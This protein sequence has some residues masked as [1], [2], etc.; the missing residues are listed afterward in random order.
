MQTY[1]HRDTGPQISTYIHTHA[2]ICM[3]TYTNTII[4]T[5]IHTRTHTPHMQANTWILLTC[6]NTH[7]VTN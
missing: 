4:K 5:H 1:T 3:Y 7:A 2:H 6:R